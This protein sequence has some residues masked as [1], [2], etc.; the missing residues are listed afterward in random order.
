MI[1]SG[2][3]NIVP[4]EIE[5]VVASHH[6]GDEVAAIGASGHGAPVAAYGVP[7]WHV[8]ASLFRGARGM[9]ITRTAG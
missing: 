3:L 4:R 6:D 9:L 7:S 1:I 2:G 5:E 8:V